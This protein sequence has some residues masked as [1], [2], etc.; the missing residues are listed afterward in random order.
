MV[1]DLTRDGL[2][3]HL[4]AARTAGLRLAERI[5]ANEHVALV[6]EPELDIVCPFLRA[7]SASAIAAASERAF[8]ALAQRG[9]HVAKL[10]LESGWLR[11]RHPWIE[12][13]AE[14]TTALRCCLMKP[15]HLAVADELADA[16]AAALAG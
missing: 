4:A 9:W 5:A 6:V 11:R 12:P 8:D 2:G 1:Y 14:T 7:P 13:D 10:R 3:A 15:E 16:L